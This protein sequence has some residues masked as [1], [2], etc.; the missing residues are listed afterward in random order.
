LFVKYRNVPESRIKN[1]RAGIPDYIDVL[2][3]TA[4][5]EVRPIM[6]EWKYPNALK[7]A[8][9]FE[10]HDQY[11]MVI[12]VAHATGSPARK[13]LL[14]TWNGDPTTVSVCPLP[15]TR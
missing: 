6:E 14:L 12:V 9:L 5:G 11:E 13:R 4:D 10:K 7:V 2:R 1:V 8:E 3:I 15:D